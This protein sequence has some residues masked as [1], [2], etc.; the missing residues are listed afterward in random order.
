MVTAMEADMLTRFFNLDR[1]MNVVVSNKSKQLFM[2]LFRHVLI[3]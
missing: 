3:M 1:D 2:F